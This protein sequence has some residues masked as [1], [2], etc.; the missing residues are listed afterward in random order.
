[1]RRFIFFVTLCLLPAIAMGKSIW[2]PGYI[3]KTNQADTLKG[4][5]MLAKHAHQIRGVHFRT[6]PRKKGTYYGVKDVTAF[7]GY[8]VGANYHYRL[9]RLNRKLEAFYNKEKVFARKLV[10]GG[11]DLFEFYPA[12][13]TKPYF[14]VVKNDSVVFV[15]PEGQTTLRGE[16]G[17]TLNQDNAVMGFLGLLDDCYDPLYAAS[18]DYSIKTFKCLAKAY[19]QCKEKLTFTAQSPRYKLHPYATVSVP[20]RATFEQTIFNYGL[21]SGTTFLNFQRGE[22]YN[23]SAGPIFGLGAELQK[24]GPFNSNIW[25]VAFTYFSADVTSENGRIEGGYNGINILVGLRRET[26]QGKIRPYLGAGLTVGSLFADENRFVYTR[27]SNS[28]AFDYTSGSHTFGYEVEAGA[29]VTGLGKL[30]LMVGAVF[31]FQGRLANTR[32]YQTTTLGPVVALRY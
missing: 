13:K 15:S 14:Y 30:S 7:G 29:R 18:L 19:N 32:P 8:G 28:E 5:I 24:D 20:V 11:I 10:G 22:T 31:S 2:M 12:N 4:E 6:G 16:G 25:R 27:N 3:I 1:M 9:I 17:G 26:K 23:F 21:V